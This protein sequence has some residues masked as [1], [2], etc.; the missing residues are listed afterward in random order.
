MK[1]S[2][3][4]SVG[5]ARTVFSAVLC[6]CYEG[7]FAQG[8]PEPPL[9]FYGTI[10]NLAQHNLRLSSGSLTWQIRKSTTGRTVSLDTVVSNYPG[11]SY[12]LEVPAETVVTGPVTTNTLD[13]TA[14]AVVFEHSHV[15]V[16]GLLVSFS[17]PAQ[18]SFSASSRSRGRIERVDLT[19]SIPCS[20]VDGNGLCDDWELRYFGAIGADPEGDDDGDG[21]RNGTEFEAGTD[22]TDARS[23]FQF[24]NYAALPAGGMQVDW[25]SV[26]GRSYRLWRGTNLASV[27]TASLPSA[28]GLTLVRSNLVATPPVNTVID[29]GASGT[30]HYFYRLEIEP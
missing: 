18:S 9:I 29:P 7:G 13:L 4:L 27:A 21:M 23:V 11:F 1:N 17:A 20:D 26:D 30:G 2:P 16:N 10:R 22:P 8:I 14:S 15:R 6:F 5:L 24:V 25:E 19:V 28:L 3:K 12:I